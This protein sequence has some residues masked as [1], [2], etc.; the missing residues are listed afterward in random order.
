MSSL[1]RPATIAIKAALVIWGLINVLEGSSRSAFSS[2]SAPFAF[3]ATPFVAL[4]YGSVLIGGSFA[5][6]SSRIVS[7]LLLA[8]SLASLGILLVARDGLGI[9]LSFR[10]ALLAILLRPALAC[11]ILY[12]VSRREAP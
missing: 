1:N 4:V 6:V 3:L 2:D 11:L 9:A 7:Y 5:F 8:V 12:A 10:E